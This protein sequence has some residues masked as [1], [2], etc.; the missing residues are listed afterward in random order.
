VF[1]FIP[2]ENATF[3][4]FEMARQI[5]LS[6]PL[7][8]QPEMARYFKTQSTEQ[9][10][11]F[12]PALVRTYNAGLAF[13]LL[14]LLLLFLGRTRCSKYCIIVQFH[15]AFSILH[16]CMHLCPAVL[17][18]SL[19]RQPCRQLC[20]AE[21]QVFLSAVGRHAALHSF[22]CRRDGRQFNASFTRN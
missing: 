3:Q 1:S 20:P 17:P 15:H 6:R 13:A 12:L 19:P 10:V 16:H 8:R 14:L 7:N 4:C 18:G 5:T 21:L 11:L 9:C 22:S 2:K